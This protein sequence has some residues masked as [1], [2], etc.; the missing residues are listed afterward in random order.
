MCLV[1]VEF[2]KE[3]ASVVKRSANVEPISLPVTEDSMLFYEMAA[4]LELLLIVLES[5]GYL[6]T[7]LLPLGG[8]HIQQIGILFALAHIA[9]TATSLKKQWLRARADGVAKERK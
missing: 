1:S 7:E 5:S 6:S 3:V 8:G 2:Y 9:T 4:I